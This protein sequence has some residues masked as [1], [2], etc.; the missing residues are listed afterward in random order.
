MFFL[1]RS[2]PVSYFL[3]L[4]GQLLF[5]LSL[6]F[7]FFLPW[8][9]LLILLQMS[10]TNLQCVSLQG[11]ECCLHLHNRRHW[12]NLHKLPIQRLHKSWDGQAKDGMEYSNWSKV[13]N[14]I[15]ATITRRSLPFWGAEYIDK[16]RIA[17]YYNLNQWLSEK[18][19]EWKIAFKYFLSPLRY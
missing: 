6:F 3:I 11:D 18:F 16:N 2:L 8:T 12:Q 10:Q 7:F 17:L 5:Q 4:C 14:L 19:T 15:T 9:S 1:S 13:K